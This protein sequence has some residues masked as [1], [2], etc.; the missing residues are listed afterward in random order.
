VTDFFKQWVHEW[1]QKHRYVHLLVCLA[2]RPSAVKLV[3]PEM[4]MHRHAAQVKR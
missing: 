4:T 3:F 2:R 1:S